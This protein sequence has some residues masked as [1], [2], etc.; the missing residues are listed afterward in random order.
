[1]K[2]ER[3][4][5]NLNSIFNPG[6]V[7]V[8]GASNDPSKL[9]HQALKALTL[10]KFERPI[11]PIHK[12][13]DRVMGL[14]A[15]Q[16]LKDL[17]SPVD[18]V[19]VAVN[20]SNV[21]SVIEECT[22]YNVKGAVVF[23][24]GFKE[25]DE[26]GMLWQKEMAALADRSDLAIIGPN[27]AGIINTYSN[28]NATFLAGIPLKRGNMSFISQSGGVSQIITNQIID[29]DLGFSKLIGVGNRCNIEF[30]DVLEYLKRDPQ[31]SAVG[32]FIEG[33][34][35]PLQLISAAKDTVKEKP[36]VIYKSARTRS[37]P[38]TAYSHTG[39][40][41]GAYHLYQV[42]FRS[43]G[44]CEVNSVQELVDTVYGLSILKFR[45][46]GY[47]ALII[48]HT[49]GPSIIALDVLEENGI[50]LA[51]LKDLTIKKI[52]ELM[53][54]G[55]PPSPNPLDMTGAAWADPELYAKILTIAAEEENV[56]AILLI[57]T[58]QYES[59]TV[60][61]WREIAEHCMNRG[62]I[63][64]LCLVYP[65]ERFADAK[66][67]MEEIGAPTLPTPDRAAKTLVN[68]L[69]FGR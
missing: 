48:T 47:R 15:Y 28:L 44:V 2:P 49:S 52:F 53:P 68:I 21:L 65:S 34:D 12:T 3:K 9:G 4:F 27:T 57:Y 55:A 56:D 17:P 22:V 20:A 61:R 30:A 16:S 69:K 41:A 64:V 43:A 66:K 63:I 26:K 39:S 36:V 7:A 59:F 11:Y 35:N 37:G 10:G 25:K 33:I 51:S 50:T 46:K 29:M 8:I 58:A 42:A 6:S 14:K 38:K 23:A 40:L 5:E 18:L 45:P 1:M 67:G 13:Y 60:G 54:S 24:S 62:K 32:I 19:I 31:T